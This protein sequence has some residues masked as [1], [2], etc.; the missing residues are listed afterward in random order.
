MET[1][2]ISITGMSCGG[3]VAGVRKALSTVLG[4]ADAQVKVGEATVNFDPA[5]TNPD[6]I[7]GAITRAGYALAAA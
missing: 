6:A 1:L 5:I 2:T 7:R 3:C 4:V